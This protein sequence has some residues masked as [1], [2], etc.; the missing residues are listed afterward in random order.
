MPNE[1]SNKSIIILII[2]AVLIVV[3]FWAYQ[4]FIAPEPEIIIENKQVE[5]FAS[6]P[7]N[8]T[9][10][11]DGQEITL[12]DGKS[13]IEIAPGSASKIVTMNF[14]EPIYGDLDG[15]GVDDAALTLTQ[16]SGGSGTFYYVAAA[17]KKEG[18]YKGTN[19]VLL[20]DRIA[21]QEIH[22]D[23]SVIV[24]NYTDRAAGESFAVQP[25]VGKTKYLYVKDGYLQEAP[26]LL[27]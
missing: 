13:E 12:I 21:P 16:N 22:F 19:A 10:I 7:L 25:S 20:G 14:G 27:K 5:T 17:L 4:K 18:G 23:G 8:A 2:I 11:I 24:A 26:A 1:R 3:G 15:D 6:D 9:Y